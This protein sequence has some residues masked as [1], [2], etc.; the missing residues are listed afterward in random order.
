MKIVHIVPGSGNTF[1]CQNCMRDNTLVTALRN[2]GHDVTAIPM[3]LPLFVD[4]NEFEDET[5]VFY[6]AINTYLKQVMPIYRKAPVWLEKVFD[7]RFLLKLAAKKSGSTDAAGLEDMTISMIM[8]EEGN[9]SSEL[10]HLI[11]WLRDHAKPDVVHLSNALLL[12]LAHNIKNKLGI[13]VVCSLQDEHQWVDPMRPEYQE[14]VWQLMA[15]K[16]QDVVAYTPVSHYYS[17]RMKKI[18]D[19]P[20]EKMHVIHVGLDLEKYSPTEFPMDPPVIGYLSRIHKDSGLGILVDAFIELKKDE[21]FNKV[22]LHI[23]GGKTTDDQQFYSSI[24][25]KLENNNCWQD[26][27]I[28]DSF[29]KDSRLQFFKAISVL[30]VPVPQGEAFGVYLIEAFA[31]GVPVVQPKVGAFPELIDMAGGGIIY[32]PNDPHK[33]SDALKSIISNPEHAVQLGKQ[34]SENACKYFC[35]EKMADD[36]VKLY[37]TLI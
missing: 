23:T 6:G 15:E 33:L 7:S 1:Y 32:E 24:K 36:M 10:D 8:G 27:V 2:R 35:I 13:P 19:I 21:K 16:G 26:V 31:S 5:P 18:M 34:G 22:Q 12:G 14:K 9:Q 29:D 30:S 4:D 3:Y 25:S 17:E 37:E 20:E 28:Y 11:S